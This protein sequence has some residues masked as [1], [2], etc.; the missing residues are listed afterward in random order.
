M[1][2]WGHPSCWHTACRGTR[3]TL[4]RA[5]RVWTGGHQRSQLQGHCAHWH[6]AA[7]GY[8]N[9]WVRSVTISQPHNVV[10]MDPFAGVGLFL[11][12]VSNCQI[13]I[14]NY[15]LQAVLTLSA[16]LL[17][18]SFPWIISKLT[19]NYYWFST[20]QSALSCCWRFES[21]W[22][23]R[24]T[25]FLSL[26][27][28]SGSAAFSPPLQ[29]QICCCSTKVLRPTVA[30]WAAEFLMDLQN[31]LNFLDNESVPTTTSGPPGSVLIQTFKV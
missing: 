5:L 3:Q 1:W 23:L 14:V 25:A 30:G 10:L 12:D 9:V 29:L 24:I 22:S 21:H 27:W 18:S 7:L 16:Q 6:K 2:K 17:A 28:V 20:A 8:D 13:F 19:K 26:L 4:R 31:T 11:Y 15:S